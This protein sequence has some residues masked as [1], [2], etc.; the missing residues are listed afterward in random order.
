MT[1]WSKK[2]NEL[3]YETRH[4]AAMVSIQDQINGLLREKQR[5]ATRYKQSLKE[6]NAHIKSCES[7]LAREDK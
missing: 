4:I 5:L 1:D 2:Y 7:D 6:I 3:P